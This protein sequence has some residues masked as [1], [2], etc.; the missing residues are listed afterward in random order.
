M[1]KFTHIRRLCKSSE[2][3]KRSAKLILTSL[4]SLTS[5]M[6]PQVKRWWLLRICRPL[7]HRQHASLAIPKVLSE[8]HVYFWLEDDLDFKLHVDSVQYFCSRQRLGRRWHIKS[9]DN[10]Y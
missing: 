10:V 5:Q 3:P 9:P 7:L 1:C 6:M 4:K 2:P 8:L